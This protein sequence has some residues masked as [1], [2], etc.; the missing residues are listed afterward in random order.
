MKRIISAVIGL[1]VTA[2]MLTAVPASAEEVYTYTKTDTSVTITGYDGSISTLEIP[3]EID[4][5]PVTAIGDSAFEGKTEITSVTIPEG[6][7]TIGE[8]SFYQCTNL[9][10]VVLPSTITEFSGGDKIPGTGSSDSRWD[11]ISYSF[12][13]CTSLKSLTLTEGMTCIGGYAFANCTSLESVT[14]PASVTK[15]GEYSFYQCTSLKD[16]TL[17]EGLTVMG[18]RAFSKTAVESVVIPSTIETWMQSVYRDRAVLPETQANCAFAECEN[19]SFVEFAEGL[20]S[21][22]YCLFDSC[23]SLKKV[24]IPASVT[25]IQYGFYNCIGLEEVCF[26]E[27]SQMTTFSSQAFRGCT[28][29]KAIDIPASIT[30]FQSEIN[31]NSFSECSSL[32]SIYLYGT[33]AI[34]MIDYIQPANQTVKYYCYPDTAMY[35]KLLSLIDRYPYLKMIGIGDITEA[36]SDALSEFNGVLNKANALDESKYTSESYS[37]LKALLDAA[38]N[39][40][41]DS[42][43]L[44]IRAITSDIESAINALEENPT[45]PSN[46]SQTEPGLVNPTKVPTAAKP[47]VTT[48]AT[49][50]SEAVA[51]DK[52]DAEKVMKQAKITKLT[53]KSKAKK[54]INVTWKKVKKAVGYEVQLSTNK[55]FK[56]NKIVYDKLTSKKKLTIKNKKIKSGKK[57][58]VRVRAYATYKDANNT[59]VKVYSA[60]NKKLRKVTVK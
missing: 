8:K 59:P 19:L 54:K 20:K 17:E 10:S 32:E 21:I 46:P 4:G 7:T 5:L 31:N 57:Y 41:E 56:K 11:K 28:N 50:S 44:N 52:A 39:Y 43:I 47:I 51:K 34:P 13:E 23:T 27:G 60:W 37:N 58:F 30:A 14:I 42:H 2:S 29:L 12:A 1:A 6:V 25:D 18:C 36:L 9:E 48:K 45:Q 24:F 38:R 49:R 26:E 53:V 16:I 35:D 33:E 15:W 40:N 22:K 55:K 3:E